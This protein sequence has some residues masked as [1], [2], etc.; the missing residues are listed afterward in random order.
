[1]IAKSWT[2]LC[3]MNVN[4]ESNVQQIVYRNECIGLYNFA[5]FTSKYG[6]TQREGSLHT[7][8][9]L[10]GW[11]AVPVVQNCPSFSAVS[12]ASQE[13][14][15]PLANRSSWLPY[16]STESFSHCQRPMGTSW[17]GWGAR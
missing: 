3:G 9:M 15:K 12:S 2:K 6:L 16:V 11:P 13:T 14:P 8:I 5:V 1:M 4:A 10:L 17:V 7:G